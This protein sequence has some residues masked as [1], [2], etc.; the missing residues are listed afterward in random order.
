MNRK[1]FV[2][3]TVGAVLLGAA[4]FL[5]RKPVPP[6]PVKRGTRQID[7]HTWVV[8]RADKEAYLG[9]LVRVTNDITL[10][11]TPGKD[12]NSVAELTIAALA[13]GSPMYAAGF[14][15]DD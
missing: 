4:V 15:K 10:K 5:I 8:S 11:P 2:A 14:R 1:V 13:E 3:V 9:D 6:E 12:E 7:P